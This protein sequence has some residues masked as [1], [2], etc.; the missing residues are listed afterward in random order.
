MSNEIILSDY[1]ETL[2]IIIRKIE[3]AQLNAIVSSNLYMMN[4]YWDIRK[5]NIR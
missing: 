1:R 3:E 4:L 5:Y 2:E